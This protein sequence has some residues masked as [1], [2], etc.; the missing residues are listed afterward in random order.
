MA[1]PAK[2]NVAIIVAIVAIGFIYDLPC[3]WLMAAYICRQVSSST[4]PE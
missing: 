3:E 1:H 4:P 2:S